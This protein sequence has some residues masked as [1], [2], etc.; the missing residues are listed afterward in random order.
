[1]D[2]GPDSAPFAGIV[3]QAVAGVKPPLASTARSDRRAGQADV[4]TL[5]R[6]GET[7]IGLDVPGCLKTVGPS[8]GKGDYW[9][10]RPKHNVRAACGV[11]RNRIERMRL[12]G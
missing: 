1:V 2:P 10:F 12:P 4:A 6:G 7:N 8:V 9:M 11:H 3:E 5:I